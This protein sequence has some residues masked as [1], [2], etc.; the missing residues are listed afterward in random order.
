VQVGLGD[1]DSPMPTARLSAQTEVL[2]AAR[3]SLTGD[4][5]PSSGDLE[6]D[7][8]TVKPGEKAKLTLSR[9]VP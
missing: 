8:V 7:P 3:L 4:V 2:L 5:K 9:S 1:A 6:A